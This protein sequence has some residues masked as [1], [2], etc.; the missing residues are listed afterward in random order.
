MVDP[1]GQQLP[2]ADAVFFEHLSSEILGRAASEGRFSFIERKVNDYELL[3][4]NR[5]EFEYNVFRWFRADRSDATIYINPNRRWRFPEYDTVNLAQAKGKIIADV[6][7]GS[8]EEIIKPETMLNE[9]HLTYFAQ[10]VRKKFASSRRCAKIP[11][12]KQRQNSC[13]T[14]NSAGP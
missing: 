3:M 9:E 4:S 5:E 1:Q 7:V 10:S 2:Y 6:V 13:E 8:N 11:S 14:S 12:S